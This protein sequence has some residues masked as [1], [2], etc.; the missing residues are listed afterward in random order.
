M[1]EPIASSPISI[2]PHLQPAPALPLPPKRPRK[3]SAKLQSTL[4]QTALT[5]HPD[6][7]TLAPT[8]NQEAS[9][10]H[11]SLMLLSPLP[12]AAQ[13]PSAAPRPPA[14][15]R[16]Q[17]KKATAVPVPQHEAAAACHGS[18]E[19]VKGNSP[20][21][22]G[23][24]EVV[25]AQLGSAHWPA[26][27]LYIDAAQVGSLSLMDLQMVKQTKGPIDAMFHQRRSHSSTWAYAA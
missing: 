20:A 23:I 18:S 10:G 15:P 19:P 24:Q 26:T 25:W 9:Q 8:S 3:P 4:K 27:V 21:G 16:K 2:P 1:L 14:K 13:I 7:I 5:G 12:S 17:F 11:T 6:A 22:I